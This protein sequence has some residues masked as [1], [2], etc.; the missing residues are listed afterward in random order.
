MNNGIDI[1]LREYT[2][3][4]YSK[5]EAYQLLIT[6]RSYVNILTLLANTIYVPTLPLDANRADDGVHLIQTFYYETTGSIHGPWYPEQCSMLDMMLALAIRGEDTMGDMD[7]GDRVGV[8]FWRMVDSLGLLIPDNKYT[9]DNYP[10]MV[11]ERFMK[12]EYSPDG[13]GGLFTL[14]GCPVDLRIVEIW[15]QMS[16]YLDRIIDSER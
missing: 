4:R 9:T 10:K 8:W 11:L 15:D 6:P 13:R 1:L 14:P 2:L 5:I 16:W 12:S 7:Q 3:W